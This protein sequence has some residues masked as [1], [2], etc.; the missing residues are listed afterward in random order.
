MRINK[1]SR[2]E[3]K[4][5]PVSTLLVA[6]TLCMILP[7]IPESAPGTTQKHI[8]YQEPELRMAFL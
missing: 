6:I 2:E 3:V 7:L 8:D 4:N 5:V 1:E